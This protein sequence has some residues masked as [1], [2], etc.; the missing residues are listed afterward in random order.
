MIKIYDVLGF[1]YFLYILR[2]LGIRFE[3]GRKI[4]VELPPV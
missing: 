4:E 2:Y 3:V 1:L